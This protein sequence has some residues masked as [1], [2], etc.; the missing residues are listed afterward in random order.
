M[1]NIRIKLVVGETERWIN[2]IY[3]EYFRPVLTD[4]DRKIDGHTLEDSTTFGEPKKEESWEEK[5]EAGFRELDLKDTQPSV[6][7]Y[8][9]CVRPKEEQGAT[10]YT[11][12][13]GGLFDIEMDSSENDEFFLEWI[14]KGR[15]EHGYFQIF[16]PHEDQIIWLEFWDGFC[17]SYQEHMSKGNRPPVMKLRISP[18]ITRN[19]KTVVQQENWKISDIDMKWKMASAPPIEEEGKLVNYH[20]ENEEGKRIKKYKIGDTIV[21]VIE[22]Q[23]KKGDTLEIDMQ[24]K[25]ADFELN[26]ERLEDDILEHTVQDDID[27]IELKVI[28]QE[29]Q[30]EA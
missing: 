8:D 16:R 29:Q 9:T 15:M 19:R 22:T 27:R 17:V 4:H 1:S 13:V 7:N 14:A 30:E 23:N 24:D 28:R 12:I 18:A 2:H 5:F 6:F 26:G 20:I 21:L 11:I 25:A 3:Y 10:L